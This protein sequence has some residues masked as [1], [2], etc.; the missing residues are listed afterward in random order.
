MLYTQSLHALD[1]AAAFLALVSSPSSSLL[2]YKVRQSFP[3]CWEAP[4]TALDSQGL[5]IDRP[6]TDVEEVQVTFEPPFDS[7]QIVS[8]L[9]PQ[10][11]SSDRLRP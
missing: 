6:L 1:S 9:L 11:A 5:G 2:N 8:K 4:T 3:Y 7:Y 10:E